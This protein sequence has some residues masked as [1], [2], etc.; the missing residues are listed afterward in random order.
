MNIL[1]KSLHIENF[2][3][4]TNADFNFSSKA[5][6]RGANASGKTT[7]VDAF[8][9]LL[10]D[11]NSQFATDF[12][13]RPLDTDGNPIHMTDITVSAIIDFDGTE[14]ELKKVQK[15]N[16]VKQRGTE[17]AVFKG[18]VNSFEIDGYP[19]TLAEYKAFIESVV[20][21][22]KFKIVTNPTY[23]P[24]LKWKEQRDTLIK[25]ATVES[26]VEIAKRVGG[27]DEI[28]DELGK[29]P[30]TDDIV[31]KYKNT[32]K[33]LENRLKEIPVRV[34]EI[35]KTKVDYDVAELELQKNDLERK[36]QE[37]SIGIDSSRAKGEL[38][39][40]EMAI[41]SL[42]TNLNASNNAKRHD[43]SMK[44]ADATARIKIA[45]TEKNTYLYG[46]EIDKKLIE[47]DKTAMEE[48][49]KA[50]FTK[51]DE[52][53][54]DSKWVYDPNSEYC[55]LC[56][57]KLPAD[58]I[59]TLKA[60]FEER[61][62][63]AI[64]VFEESKKYEMQTLI[65][66]GNALK[67]KIAKCQNSIEERE[68]KSIEY[69]MSIESA[70]M[71]KETLEKELA[72]LPESVDITSN[73]EYI[74]LT[75]KRDELST[76]V[77]DL[78]TINTK[79]MFD[80]TSIECDLHE[81][82]RKLLQASGNEKIDERIETLKA[83]Q[84][85]VAQKIANCEKVLFLVENFV[86]AKMDVISENINSK[87][88]MAKFSL[89]ETQINGSVVERC[90]ATYNGVDYNN[91]NNGHKV[92]VGLDICKTFAREYGIHSPIF[93]DN[94]ESI[95]DYNLPIL[96]SQL[97]LLKVSDDKELVIESEV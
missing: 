88:E 77:N 90:V 20:A 79:A 86:K 82:N 53:F 50:F 52:K 92:V 54:D 30:S 64:S 45:E 4:I 41:N 60:E 51:R 97:I 91:L 49:S 48:M 95:N 73:A 71:E 75:K 83:E 5:T 61:K 93:V 39:E 57:Q 8:T 94:A 65:D 16:W 34:D 7:I 58:K 14:H 74:A 89:W 59:D 67:E 24:N 29:A 68:S 43:L 85:E 32:K 35:S 18:N 6:V 63:K 62:A 42:V 22:D 70:Q 15:E 21:E 11:K 81:V 33:E 12:E 19:K 76:E 72:T 69:T 1:L 26:D 56:G 17:T 40:T 96:D 46:L 78:E 28:I 47:A 23:F 38:M 44:I 27:F 13:I 37:F 36:L 80:R 31:K 66:R 55:A 84:R 87:F 10:F 9:W 2:K 3:G 25:F